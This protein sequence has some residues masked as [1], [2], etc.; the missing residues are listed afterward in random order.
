MT[1][2]IIVYLLFFGATTFLGLRMYKKYFKKKLVGNS[3]K[4]CGSD[5]CGCG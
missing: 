1:Q 2:E 5:D 3:E 4:S